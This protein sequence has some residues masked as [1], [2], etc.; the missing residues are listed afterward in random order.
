MVSGDDKKLRVALTGVSSS[1]SSVGGMTPEEEDQMMRRRRF[2]QAGIGVSLVLTVG[3]L[4]ALSVTGGLRPI[5]KVTA[6]REPPAD[7]DELV[8]ADDQGTIIAPESLTVGSGML[9][10][11]PR[12]PASKVVKSGTVDNLILLTRLDPAS[13]SEAT[14]AQ[15]ADGIVGYSALCPHLGCTVS[16][17]DE[18]HDWFHCP[19]HHAEFDPSDDAKVVAGPSP[20]PLP[21]LPLKLSGGSLLVAGA[22]LTP[23]GAG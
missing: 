3:G 1:S 18:A 12:D 19:C 6:D 22:F 5:A 8:A 23:V 14:R 17:W 4:S 20:R 10:A 7:G 11:Y 2:I 21:A 13:L 16:L 9:M 15:A